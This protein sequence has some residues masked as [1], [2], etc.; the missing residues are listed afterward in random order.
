MIIKQGGGNTVLCFGSYNERGILADEFK[1]TYIGKLKAWQVQAWRLSRLISRF[2]RATVELGLKGK[3]FYSDI[4]NF[5]SSLYDMGI[6]L[7]YV[8]G[9]YRIVCDSD[10]TP[11]SPSREDA[12]AVRSL[13]IYGQQIWRDIKDL[14]RYAEHPLQKAVDER[15]DRILEY[16]S[17]YADIEIDSTA[18]EVETIYVERGPGWQGIHWRALNTTASDKSV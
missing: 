5:L 1:A 8:E 9:R 10:L 15:T 14:P 16:V 7:H 17:L 18:A 12:E 4:E 13:R 2:P 3:Y 11:I 6:R